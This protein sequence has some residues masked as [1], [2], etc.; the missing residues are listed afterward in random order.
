MN[1]N[2]RPGKNLKIFLLFL[3]VVF[4]GS[5]LVYKNYYAAD[6]QKDKTEQKEEPVEK[7][8]SKEENLQSGISVGP[9]NIANIVA[10]VSPAVVNIET[11]IVSKA[12]GNDYLFNDPFFREF[13]GDNITRPKENIQ[14]GIGT[15]FIISENGYILTNQHV[16]EDADKISVNLS[17]EKKYE[18]EVVGQDY[19]LDLA[20]LKI[21]TDEKFEPL[22]IG[23]SEQL[24]VGEWVIA[25][26][27]PYGLDHTVTAGVI[28]AKGRPIQI[29]NRVYKNLIQTDAAINPGNSGGPL[30]NTSG[31]VIAINTAVN[32]EAQGIGFAIP[33]NTA[34]DVLDELI[35]KGKVIR[36][37]MG[38]YL[39]SM[40][41]ERAQYLGVKPEGIIVVGIEEGSPAEE[42]GLEI[43]DVIIS[44]DKVKLESYEKLQDILKD[45]H[46]G[47]KIV[48][49]VLRN[50]KQLILPLVLAEKP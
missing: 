42:A 1:E 6:L 22:K 16:I 45:K 9:S 21:N 3:L 46:V 48:L 7:S 44:L 33:I 36:P 31:E 26:G 20:V 41:E 43:Y 29:Q 24:R 23:D 32:A 11:S 34:R 37:Y 39:Q 30:L 15:G 12:Y 4:A 47:D 28:S 8:Q 5:L 18:A 40:N 2:S 49:E 50:G 19:E 38:V 27:N 17:G 25:I 35:E 13:F 10:K 14:N